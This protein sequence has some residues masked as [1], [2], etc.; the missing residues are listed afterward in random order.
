MRIASSSDPPRRT[1]RLASSAKGNGVDLSDIEQS[2]SLEELPWMRRLFQRMN[3]AMTMKKT[4]ITK[5]YADVSD[6]SDAMIDLY[7]AFMRVAAGE[8]CRIDFEVITEN[9]E[10]TAKRPLS[11]VRSE[12]P[13]HDAGQAATNDEEGVE[14]MVLDEKQGKTFDAFLSGGEGV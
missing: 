1:P 11:L 2:M 13:A 14:V 9:E 4:L 3:T 12:H 8:E 6:Q 10:A 5:V 7:K